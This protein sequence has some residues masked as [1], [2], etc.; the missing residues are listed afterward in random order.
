M[1]IVV[2][3][4]DG[5]H[6]LSHKYLVWLLGGLIGSCVPLSSRASPLLGVRS[7]A[8]RLDSVVCIGWPKHL[9]YASYIY[10]IG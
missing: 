8:R 1:N 3:V 10:S 2:F 7:N 5:A 9:I 6:R 4:S